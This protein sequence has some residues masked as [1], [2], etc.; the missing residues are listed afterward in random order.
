MPGMRDTALLYAAGP[1][2]HQ[3]KENPQLAAIVE[4][5]RQVPEFNEAVEDLRRK[6]EHKRYY[7]R[8]MSKPRP[9]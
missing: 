9:E 1:L 2:L 5:L 7:G 4:E 3:A 8:F 6:G